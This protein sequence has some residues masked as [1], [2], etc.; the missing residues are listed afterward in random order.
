MRLEAEDGIRGGELNH[1]TPER[2]CRRRESKQNLSNV[3]RLTSA[4]SFPASA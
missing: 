3:L 1:E 2:A 4:H